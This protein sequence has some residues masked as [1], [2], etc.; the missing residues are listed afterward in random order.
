MPK[1]TPEV[2]AEEFD[3]WRS[4]FVPSNSDRMTPNFHV[5]GGC[6]V[7]R[8]EPAYPGVLAE[9]LET[10]APARLTLIGNPALLGLPK[11]ALFCS[12]R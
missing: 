2:K 9:R 4:Q 8:Y 1:K 11:T 6:V 5:G 7:C 10:E 3:N 12:A